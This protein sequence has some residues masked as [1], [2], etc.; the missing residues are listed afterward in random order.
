MSLGNV[1]FFVYLTAFA[2]RVANVLSVKMSVSPKGSSPDP[3]SLL[4]PPFWLGICEDYLLRDEL[5]RITCFG[6]NSLMPTPAPKTSHRFIELWLQ[7][8]KYSSSD[9]SLTFSLRIE[10]RIATVDTGCGD[11]APHSISGSRSFP[12]RAI[13]GKGLVR[14]APWRASS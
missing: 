1:S 7:R 5:G 3:G 9:H 12:I 13:A 4:R 10:D 8:E 2:R 6:K 14:G 11:G